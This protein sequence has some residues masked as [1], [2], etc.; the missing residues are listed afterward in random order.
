[1][2]DVANLKKD[3]ASKSKT[4]LPGITTGYPALTKIEAK[5]KPFWKQSFPED[6]SKITITTQI[7]EK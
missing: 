1:M 3:V 5:V 2:P 6:I 4:A 7:D